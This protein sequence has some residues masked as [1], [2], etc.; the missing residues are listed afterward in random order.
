MTDK[1]DESRKV[2]V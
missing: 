2:V 1:Y